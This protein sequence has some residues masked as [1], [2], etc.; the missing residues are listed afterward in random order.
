MSLQNEESNEVDFLY[1]DPS[2]SGQ[3]FGLVSFAEPIG[4]VFEKKENF[5]FNKFLK[6]V[7]E[8]YKLDTSILEEYENF[9]YTFRENLQED[10]N[11]EFDFKCNLRGFKIR[12]AFDSPEIA[13]RKAKSLRRLEPAF[14]IFKCEIGKWS[15]FNPEPDSI[16]NDDYDEKGLNELIK[17]HNENQNQKDVYFEERVSEMKKDAIK[18]NEKKINFNKND[19]D[20]IELNETNSSVP[21]NDDT[22]EQKLLVLEDDT[23]SD[24]NLKNIVNDIFN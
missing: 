21:V 13:D 2:I 19:V 24:K 20:V 4:D 9:K 5:Y 14:H 12:G 22:E 8:K 11:K 18:N 16:G 1:E 7:C 15:I 6:S 23:E 3:K 10:F 17:T